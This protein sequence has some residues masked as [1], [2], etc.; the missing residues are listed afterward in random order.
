MPI[1]LRGVG[2]TVLLNRFT[3]I[4]EAEG[5]LVAYI[6][7]PETGDLRMLLASRLRKVLLQLDRSGAARM[8]L[9]ALRVLKTFT[10][11]LPDGGA[12]CSSTSTRSRARPTR[13]TSP[14]T[15][16]TCWSPSAR[17]LASAAPALL[18]AIDEVQYLS[19]DELG[20]L[21]TA[22]HRTIQL[23]LPVVL[24]GAGAAPAAR[25]RGRRQVVRRTALR[26]PPH[27]L[28]HRRRRR[29]GVW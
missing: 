23:D 12:R 29:G 16:P 1:G 13:A 18:V 7:S 5:M 3:E 8:V 19:S 24:V 28:A 4:A 27:R 6:E 25:P 15:S 21:I 11:Q 10:L 2:K 17:R 26:V 22:I 9:R 14:T 20:A